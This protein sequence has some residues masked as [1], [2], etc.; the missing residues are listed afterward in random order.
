M[1]VR[2]DVAAAP[3]GDDRDVEQLG[4]PEEVRRR[5]G[6]E[7]PAAGEDDRSARGRD[8]LEHGAD[9]VRLRPGRRGARRCRAPCPR[10]G[11]RR[12]GPRGARA[13]PGR[14]GRPSAARIASP[15]AAGTSA[16]LRGSAANA[17]RPPNVAA[18]STSWNASRPQ[19]LALDLADEGEHR[20][21]VLARGVD[22]DREVG[23]A[24]GARADGRGRAARELAV[25]LGHER[26]G[27]LVARGDD[28]D[29]GGVE[30]L[31]QA[32]EALAGHGEG[33]ADADGAE[34]VGDEPTD[35]PGRR[36][37]R[38]RSGLGGRGL[39]RLARLGVGRRLGRLRRARLGGGSI[40]ARPR[41][42]RLARLRLGGVRP[43]SGVGS[44]SAV[45]LCLG[46][47]LRLGGVRLGLGRRARPRPGLPRPRALRRRPPTP[48]DRPSSP[49]R[50]RP[51]R[52]GRQVVCVPLRR[53]RGAAAGAATIAR[54][55]PATTTT[56]T[57]IIATRA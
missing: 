37:Q 38:L 40:G 29:A 11:P 51:V 21:R 32:E 20:R 44:G 43:R 47:R 26:G 18:W 34:G 56:A 17:A 49:S 46:V 19:Q 48:S 52:L 15:T 42:R 57:T 22:A 9:V 30:A 3:A 23:G 10:A 53:H 28:P 25:G 16:A 35:G 50:F 5:P 27:A 4:E 33:V 8:E 13:E 2:D 55:S 24:D 6:P 39:A 36:R 54:T 31:E 41:L 7:D 45:W 12:G 14:A 1:V